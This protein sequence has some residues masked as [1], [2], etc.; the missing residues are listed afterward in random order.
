VT[1][2][3]I[4]AYDGGASHTVG[5]DA[6]RTR[7]QFSMGQAVETRGM[8]ERAGIECRLLSGGSTGID[9]HLQHRL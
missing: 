4:Q 3:G 9:R 6:R 5:F 2:A 1:L 7:S 8:L